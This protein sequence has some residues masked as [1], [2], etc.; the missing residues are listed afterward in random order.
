[1][2]KVAADFSDFY[3]CC[4]GV[5]HVFQTKMCSKLSMDEIKRSKIYLIF[6]PKLTNQTSSKKTI[7]VTAIAICTRKSRGG[8]KENETQLILYR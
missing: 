7:S 1:M 2:H 4:G 8:L 5:V 6:L 3:P